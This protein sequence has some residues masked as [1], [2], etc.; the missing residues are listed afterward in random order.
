MLTATDILKIGH[1]SVSRART[2]PLGG[3]NCVGFQTEIGFQQVVG[4]WFLLP[5]TLTVDLKTAI[6]TIYWS[7]ASGIISG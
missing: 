6:E 3:V 7:Y 5:L 4:E 2:L 1:Q